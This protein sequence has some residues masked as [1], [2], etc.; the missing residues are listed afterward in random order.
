[1]IYF[2]TN[3][4]LCFDLAISILFMD[5]FDFV[6]NHKE[7]YAPP[8]ED[9]VIVTVPSINFIM[10]DGKGDPNKA[11]EYQNAVEA[12][13]S[14][15]Y[16]IKFMPK[17]GYSIPGYYD[18]K[19]GTL[20]GLWWMDGNTD[21]VNTDKSNWQWTMMIR[22]AD[23]V[24]DKVF[25]QAVE[26]TKQKKPNPSLDLLRLQNYQEGTCVQIMHIGPYSE[27]HAN[28]MLMHEFAKSK[29]YKLHGKHHEIYLGDPRKAKP[30]KLKT[31][32]RQPISK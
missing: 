14:V 6:K 8:T 12:L 3:A 10:I 28:I 21:F 15:S 16:T 29:G 19:V 9:P 4:K 7:L 2:T 30:Q 31:V 20:E 23:F 11:R 5:K 27:E 22:Q 32:L 24:T 17:K 26:L 18:F 1:M 25:N 13:Y